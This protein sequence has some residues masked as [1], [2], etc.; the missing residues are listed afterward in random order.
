MLKK[1][2]RVVWTALYGGSLMVQKM[3]NGSYQNWSSYQEGEHPEY[4]K[5]TKLIVKWENLRLRKEIL[6]QK[7][8]MAQR[9]YFEKLARAEAVAKKMGSLSEQIR[10]IK[11]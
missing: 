9:V 8:V 3:V 5:R 1:P 10:S 4:D 11:P 7:A 6:D 2:D